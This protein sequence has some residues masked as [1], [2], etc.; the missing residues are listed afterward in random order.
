MFLQE[1]GNISLIPNFQEEKD[2]AE[3]KRTVLEYPFRLCS[4]LQYRIHY[5]GMQLNLLAWC[6]L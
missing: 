4:K 3:V 5:G 2:D 6:F 1:G